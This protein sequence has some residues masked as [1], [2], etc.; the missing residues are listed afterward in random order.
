MITGCNIAGDVPEDSAS[1]F[2]DLD[3]AVAEQGHQEGQGT[4][5]RAD[6]RLER[7]TD[8]QR[9]SVMLRDGS[10]SM[11]GGR[12]KNLIEKNQDF[13]S[14]LSRVESSWLRQ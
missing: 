5:H 3:A 1:V 11:R 9:R 7:K 2:Y 14:T 10:N 6:V 4:L 13:G 8:R 12:K